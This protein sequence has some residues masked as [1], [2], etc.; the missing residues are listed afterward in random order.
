M[1]VLFIY[2]IPQYIIG[3]NELMQNLRKKVAAAISADLSPYQI[4]VFLPL[5]TLGWDE[6]GVVVLIMGLN[7]ELNRDS[8]AQEV[9]E[10]IADWIEREPT[11]RKEY[12]QFIR[13]F[14]PYA[15]TL[16]DV[17]FQKNLEVAEKKS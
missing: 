7:Q 9:G 1:P 10:T 2:G 4:S 11:T 15:D 17:L 13:V 16:R 8:V 3:T 14:I 6:K 12:V 5:A